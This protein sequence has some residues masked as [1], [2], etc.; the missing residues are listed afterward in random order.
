[1]TGGGATTRRIATYVGRERVFAERTDALAVED[2]LEI[3]VGGRP[4]S[5]TMRTPGSD[6]ELALGFLFGEGII[7][8]RGDVASA[9]IA[10]RHG[11]TVEIELAQ[12]RRA[13][14]DLT[15]HFYTTSSCGVCGKASVDAIRTAAGIDL[16]DPVRFE[17]EVLLDLPRRLREAQGL[18]AETGGLHAAGLFDDR[19]ELT[20][21]HEDV[22]R[23][24]AVDKVVGA[25]F[26]SG[27][28]PLHG[29]ALL[30]SGRASFELVQKAAMARVPVLLAVG[31]PSS[32][33]VEL[34]DDVGMTL[35]GFL[36]DG[37]FNV[38]AGGERITAA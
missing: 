27:A 24:N 20:T 8:E 30:V 21:L 13:L 33:A 31:A 25:A 3:R 1:M 36:R 18:F 7:A 17:A 2:P 10:G 15:R 37:R 6:I 4:I 19:G 23:H 26:S 14:P 22:G 29:T 9:R 34:A 11:G 38:Y 28:L 5:V 12:S 32:L 35:V 16:D